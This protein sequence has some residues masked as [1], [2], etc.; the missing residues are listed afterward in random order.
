MGNET[1]R[2]P[3]AEAVLWQGPGWDHLRGKWPGGCGSLSITPSK[4]G[5]TGT[6]GARLDPIEER[7]LARRSF[8]HCTPDIGGLHA[9]VMVEGHVCVCVCMCVHARTR[10]QHVAVPREPTSHYRTVSRH[11][12]EGP[13]SE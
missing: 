1:V 2:P 6:Q 5:P 8:P 13:I 3:V 11:N 12:F 7:V 4:T 10:V 9:R